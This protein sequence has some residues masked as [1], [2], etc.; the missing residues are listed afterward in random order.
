MTSRRDKMMKAMDARREELMH[1]SEEGREAVLRR[2][3]MTREEMARRAEEIREQ[4]A[5]RVTTE[6]VVG[7]AGWTLISAGI[8]WG[9]SDWMRGQRSMR[10]LLLPIVL[11]ASGTAVLGGGNVWHRRSH[12]ISEAEMRVREELSGLDPFARVR[13]LKDMSQETLPLVRRITWRHN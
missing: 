3:E 8:A 1:R 4:F 2:A 5:E 12:H 13:V 7:F 6:A 9:V 11:V 10:S